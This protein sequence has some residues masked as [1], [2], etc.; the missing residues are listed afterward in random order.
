MIYFCIKTAKISQILEIDSSLDHGDKSAA[1][2]GH[3]KTSNS[4]PSE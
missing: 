1:Q 3:D 4:A 2:S